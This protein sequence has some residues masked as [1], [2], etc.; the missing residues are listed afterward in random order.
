MSVLPRYSVCYV[1]F[2]REYFAG[3]TKTSLAAKKKQYESISIKRR[4]GLCCV[5]LSGILVNLSFWTY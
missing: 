4:F 5:K 1:P 2:R 3:E